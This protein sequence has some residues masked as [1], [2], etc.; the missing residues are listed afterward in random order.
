MLL[1]ILDPWYKSLQIIQNYVGLKMAMQN[2]DKIWSW[3]FDAII[4]MPPFDCWT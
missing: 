1:L 2:C 4:L 3:N